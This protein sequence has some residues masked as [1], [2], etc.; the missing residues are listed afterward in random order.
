MIDFLFVGNGGRGGGCRV[1]VWCSRHLLHKPLEFENT[2]QSWAD[3]QLPRRLAP[4]GTYLFGEQ[5]KDLQ[6][7]SSIQRAEGWLKDSRR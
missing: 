2:G 4:I 6:G 7:S 3:P 5:R 1:A